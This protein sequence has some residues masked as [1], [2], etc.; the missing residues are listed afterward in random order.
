M[1]QPISAIL[2]LDIGR[3]NTRASLFTIQNG[4]YRF[5]AGA[6]S[7]TS[8]GQEGR[9]SRGV[10]DAV[11]D[12]QQKTNRILLKP[13]GSPYTMDQDI[14]L[15]VD[16]IALTSSAGTSIKTVLLGLAEKGSLDSGKLLTDSLPIN[17]VG[18]FGL[19]ELSHETQMADKLIALRPELI[20]LTGGED[21]GAKKTIRTLGGGCEIGMQGDARCC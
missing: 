4:R 14:R 15:S 8:L 19:S 20:I 11:R 9:I 3:V 16:R 13:T 7:P 10:V 5:H 6:A 21:D 12:L 18:A 2:G 1:S 17:L